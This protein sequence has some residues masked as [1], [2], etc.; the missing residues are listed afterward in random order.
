MGWGIHQRA[1][2]DFP[3]RL[4]LDHQSDPGDQTQHKSRLLDQRN[5][6]LCDL[7]CL[8]DWVEL[9]FTRRLGCGDRARP[10]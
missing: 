6:E 3:D 5:D 10:P 7:Q 9:A 2:D 8:D 4:A 1:D